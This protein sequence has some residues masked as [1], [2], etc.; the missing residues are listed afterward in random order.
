MCRKLIYIYLVCFVLALAGEAWADTIAY[1]RF[2]DQ[3][4]PD[5]DFSEG[6]ATEVAAGNPLPDIDAQAGWDSGNYRK[7]VH[8]WSGNGNHL[9][10]WDYSWAGWEWDSNVPASNVPSTGAYNALSME[11]TQAMGSYPASFTWSAQSSPIGIDIEEIEPNQFTI[12]ASF[13]TN[14]TGWSHT[15]VGRDAMGVNT[16]TGGDLPRAA[17]Y[18]QILNYGLPT[19]QFADVSGYWHFAQ[20]NDSVSTGK[21]YHMVGVSDGNTTSLYL[22]DV[23][24]GRGF[25]LVAQTDMTASGS[26]D[27]SLTNG[28][29][30]DPNTDVDWYAGTWSVGRGLY[31][32]NH[33][34]R[35]FGYIDEVRIS[36]TALKPSQ[37]LFQQWASD[38][39]PADE[40]DTSTSVVL[41]WDPIPSATGHDVYFG[42]D[43]TKVTDA[44]RDNQL[45]VLVQQNYGSNSYPVSGLTP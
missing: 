22:A 24:A 32:A 4:I 1:W 27:T 26:P 11:H 8:D 37:F 9:T 44:N 28:K 16:Q 43:E 31:D 30:A 15:I 19:F 14:Q 12:E 41:S 6:L 42:T 39:D 40:S 25:Q 33:T 35:Y 23:E 17:L 34:D 18:F 13:F 38:P 5:I 36:D 20:A 10:T 21:W 45:G 29:S 2:D 3:D 7:A